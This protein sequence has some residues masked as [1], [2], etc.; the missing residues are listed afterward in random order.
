MCIRDRYYTVNQ[1]IVDKSV[2]IGY[3]TGYR[4][5][6]S[7]YFRKNMKTEMCIRDSLWVQ[8]EKENSISIDEHNSFE[9][10]FS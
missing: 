9:F 10:S 5:Q 6:S 7:T 8:P 1:S 3:R 4:L 2:S